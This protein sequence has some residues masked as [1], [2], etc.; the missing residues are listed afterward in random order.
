MDSDTW[1]PSSASRLGNLTVLPRYKVCNIHAFPCHVMLK[2]CASAYDGSMPLQYAV[3]SSKLVNF[4]KHYR[5]NTEQ[6]VPSK[7]IVRTVGK[8]RQSRSHYSETVLYQVQYK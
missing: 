8:E 6:S 3:C 4:I 2:Y 7:A 1:I 5:V